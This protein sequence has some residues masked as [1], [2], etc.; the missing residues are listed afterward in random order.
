MN[1]KRW[2]QH[3]VAAVWFLAFA[4]M[5]GSEEAER[6]LRWLDTA[7]LALIVLAVGLFLLAA[8]LLGRGLSA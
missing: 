3:L 6:A 5:W 8:F 2:L 7:L 1:P 4:A